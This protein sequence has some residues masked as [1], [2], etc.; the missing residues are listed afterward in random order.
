MTWLLSDSVALTED[1]KVPGAGC[2]VDQVNMGTCDARDVATEAFSVRPTGG[3]A[4][5]EANLELRLPSPIFEDRL[6]TAVFV[7][8]GQVWARRS[9]LDLG[10]MVSTPGFG[11]RYE[12]PVGP[13]RLDVAYNT[14]GPETL[15]VLTAGVCRA[16][17]EGCGMA[18][19]EQPEQEY[20]A[21]ETLITLVQA[22]RWDPLE[23]FWDRLQI[24]FS[25]GQAF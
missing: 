1:R 23:T 6:R 25:I 20:R 18:G 5:I 16:G 9:D 14:Q 12:S 7:D 13:I 19:S 4:V 21:S 22:R 2:T 3:Q 11:V 17:E 10:E 15:R 8:V 24:H